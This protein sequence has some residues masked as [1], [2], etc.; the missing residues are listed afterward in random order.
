MAR[1]IHHRAFECI[2]PGMAEFTVSHY[3]L[4][5]IWNCAMDT[6]GISWWWSQLNHRAALAGLLI[7]HH[8]CSRRFERTTE[9]TE[10]IVRL[11]IGLT[12]CPLCKS[13]GYRSMKQSS[14]RI[15][16]LL[17]PLAVVLYVFHMQEILGYRGEN[18][19]RVNWL[20]LFSL[21]L[22]LIFA[23]SHVCI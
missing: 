12:F 10:K 15:W 4:V 18:P 20:P 19:E 6:N 14:S 5:V 1:T 17:L 8:I 13:G 2:W 11:S 9:D 21:Y 3:S 16:S 23:N 22:C 7:Q